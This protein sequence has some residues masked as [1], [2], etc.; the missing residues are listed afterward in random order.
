VFSVE[1]P[2]ISAAMLERKINN[3]EASGAPVVVACDSGCLTNI[4]G[5]LH[6][7]GKPQRVVYIAEV[8]DGL[9]VHTL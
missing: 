5:G 3:I 2:E 9:D 6:R 4:N 7:R 8:L 1:H